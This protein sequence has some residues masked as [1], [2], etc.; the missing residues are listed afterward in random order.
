MNNKVENNNVENAVVEIINK[1]IQGI[2]ST[3]DF[4]LSEIPEVIQQLLMW[5]FAKSLVLCVLFFSLSIVVAIY[6]FKALKESANSEL[7]FILFCFLAIFVPVTL[8]NNSWLMI[9]IAP[10]VW[11]IEYAAN[12]V[13]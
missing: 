4:L 11:L 6:L 13:R 1:A 3:T 9:W 7:I 8:L 2:D 5:H 12:L 10:K